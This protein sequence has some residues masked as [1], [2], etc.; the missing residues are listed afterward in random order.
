MQSYIGLLAWWHCRS[1]RRAVSV[2]AQTAT[3]SGNGSSDNSGNWENGA[4]WTGGAGAGGIPAATDNASLLNVVAAGTRNINIS[5]GSPETINQLTMTQTTV[6]Q[7][8]VLN[9]NDNL[10]ISGNSNPFA[11][12]AT[13]GQGSIVTNIAASETL[14]AT[15]AGG[16][17]GSFGGTLNLSSGSLFELQTTGS[18]ND[19]GITSFAGPINATG[20]GGQYT[21]FVWPL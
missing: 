14:L 9:V 12:T 6:G 19:M 2:Q 5:S 20:A 11:I 18:T 13:A 17:T 10:T 3:W 7:L 1:S 4:N 15:N 8:N 21:P 16:L